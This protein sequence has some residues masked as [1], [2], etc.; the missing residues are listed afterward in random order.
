MGVRL[1]SRAI[2]HVWHAL[3]LLCVA[4]SWIS[5]YQTNTATA[6]SPGIDVTVYNNFG[7]NS[8]PPLPDVSGRPSVGTT[9]Y[10]NIDQN[11]DATPPF[12]LTEDF[13]VKYE[14]HITSP[15]TGDVLFWPWADDGTM[16]YLDGVLIDNGNWVDKGGGGYETGPQSFVAG[17]SKPFTYWFYENGGGAWTTLYWNIGNGWEIVPPSAFTKTQTVATTTTT[18]APY[19]NPVTNLIAV[20]KPDGGVDVNWNTPELSNLE[21]YAYAV[22]FYKLEDG[23]ESGGWGVWTE[24][25]PY[26]LGPW[27]WT[28]TTGYGEVRLKVKPGTTACFAPSNLQCFYGPEEYVDVLIEDP[29]PPTTTTTVAT[30]TTLPIVPP[31]IVEPPETI[32]PEQSSTTTTSTQPISTTTTQVVPQPSTTVPVFVQSTT[33]TQVVPQPSTTV[34]VFVQSTTSSTSTTTIPQT[35]TTLLT[36]EETEKQQIKNE[37]T[38]IINEGLNSEKVVEVLSNPEVLESIDTEQASEIFK[39]ID[40]SEMTEQQLEQIVDA[41]QS[42]PVEIRETFED[43]VDLFDGGFDE[44]KMVDSEISVGERRTVI[45]V[46]LVTASVATAA[47]A[48]GGAAG[49]PSGGTGGS[50]GGGS[51]GGSGGASGTAAKRNEEEESEMAGEIAGDGYDWVSK[52]SIYK[53]KGE[54]RVLDWKAFI[55]KFILGLLNLSFTIAG[56]VVVYFT[57]SGSIQK[58]ALISTL[59]AL[60][61]SMY[62][63]M[64]EPEQ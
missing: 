35:I 40:T 44:Y 9:T 22:S 28:G 17:N 6:L 36:N 47:L 13:I 63:H 15:V 56:S 8:S 23:I 61:A 46:N 30:T 10:A 27:M 39:S 24:Q 59:V 57:L 14:G 54:E 12:G 34:P 60:T 2:T 55:K 1:H 18:L 20:V 51:K 31:Q 26:N 38:N 48:S 41:V 7:Y 49:G 53:I 19:F 42:A 58:I 37:I 43:T 50:G 45:A 4:M 25:P 3:L 29:T 5:F 21:I 32:A 33:T 16:F 62:L 52:I 11:F 64:K